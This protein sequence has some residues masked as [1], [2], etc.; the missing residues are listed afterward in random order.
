[1]RVAGATSIFVFEVP[2]LVGVRHGGGLLL[3]GLMCFGD[4]SGRWFEV[5]VDGGMWCLKILQETF[6]A[7]LL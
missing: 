7:G 5:M 3:A 4:V 6:I 1:M 2:D